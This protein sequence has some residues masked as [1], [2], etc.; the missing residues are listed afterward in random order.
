M[1]L[2]KGFTFIEILIVMIIVGLL[3]YI[4]IP[5]ILRTQGSL[6]EKA[7]RESLNSFHEANDSFRKSQNPPRY[8]ASLDELVD[9]K[10]GQLRYL[11]MTW[12]TPVRDGYKLSY[13]AS[14]EEV[15][16]AYSMLAVPLSNS[17]AAKETYCIDQKGSILMSKGGK[18]APTASKS[19]C[20]GGAA[21]AA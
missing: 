21:I 15:G 9:A 2:L 16:G 11:D 3:A 10:P 4:A 14:D 1:K 5:N 17:Q 13:L 19:G 7:I 18:N 8:A 6:K 20:F 12:K